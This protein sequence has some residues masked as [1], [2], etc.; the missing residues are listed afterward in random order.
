MTDAQCRATRPVRTTHGA[1]SSLRFQEENAQR[2]VS[3][4]HR[5]R[6]LHHAKGTENN[7]SHK[8]VSL[9][10]ATL[11][12]P[13]LLHVFSLPFVHFIP[14]S[15]LLPLFCLLSLFFSILPASCFP[16]IPLH[17][18][19][20]PSLSQANSPFYTFILQS[21]PQDLGLG[22]R[23]TQIIADS[24][25]MVNKGPLLPSL[26][27]PQPIKF[28]SVE[29]ILYAIFRTEHQGNHVLVITVSGWQFHS[30]SHKTGAPWSWGMGGWGGGVGTVALT[31]A[32]KG[33]S[34]S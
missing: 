29:D 9:F 17:L 8:S 33:Q 14:L 28:Q 22:N 10:L 20:G 21:L 3:F 4:H 1:L 19:V 5:D 30:Q 24:Q 32:W 27:N 26:I 15:L 2:A 16:F 18:S 13:Y 12:F 34:D 11:L 31:E 23:V 25:S 6:R 7:V